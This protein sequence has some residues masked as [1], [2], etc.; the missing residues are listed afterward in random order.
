MKTSLSHW[1]AT[2]ALA[3]LV[4]LALPLEAAANDYSIG[5]ATKRGVSGQEYYWAPG[6]C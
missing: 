5:A 1:I 2:F 4:A 6:G 3:G